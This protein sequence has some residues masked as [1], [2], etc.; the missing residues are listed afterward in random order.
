MVRIAEDIISPLLELPWVSPWEM[1]E[2]DDVLAE[3]SGRASSSTKMG[4]HSNGARTVAVLAEALAALLED[5]DILRW[6]WLLRIVG[7]TKATGM[8]RAENNGCSSNLLNQFFRP[9][10][11]QAFYSPQ[12][13]T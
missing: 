4:L 2:E 3:L 12:Q 7:K 6:L 8:L 11:Q 1:P 9:A 10:D 13:H 5:A